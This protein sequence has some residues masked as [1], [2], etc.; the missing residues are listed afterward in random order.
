M[1]SV[2]L[3]DIRE[4]EQILKIG[5]KSFYAASRVLPARVRVPSM[6][7]YA[8]CRAADDAVD[9]ALP[10]EEQK[11]RAVDR[12]EERLERVYEGRAL[13]GVIE[14]VF[15]AV[16]ND[17]QIPRAL[18]AA[19]I[20]G[21]RWDAEGR[22][23]ETLDELNDYCARVASTVGV[24]MTIL[25]GP[26]GET[27]LARACDLG[28]A[29]QLTN[30]ARDVGED[31]RLGRIYLP[32]KWLREEGI[33]PERWLA[34]PAPSEPIA[35]VTARLLTAADSLYARADHGIPMLPRDCRIA[36]RA[37]RLIY[38]DI[39][40]VVRA[41]RYDSVSSRAVVSKGRKVWLIVRALGA[42]FGGTIRGDEPALPATSFLIDAAK[43]ERS[44]QLGAG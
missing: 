44:F 8:F 28:V 41:H 6:A 43:S 12:L 32:R 1:R 3:G 16:V 21:M 20:E 24:M 14:R 19:L 5:S 42:Y 23:Y 9:D 7:L 10:L 25:M 11:K 31:A 13:D 18:P 36:I 22:T 34:N 39:G 40:R 4:C 35:R 26:R 38:C 27:V 17:Y 29:M 33:D 30:I 15:S 37:A 2:C